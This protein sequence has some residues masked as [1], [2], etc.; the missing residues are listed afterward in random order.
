MAKRR[1]KKKNANL[2][3]A[4]VAIAFAALAVCTL[5]MPVFTTK[6]TIVKNTTTSSVAGKDLLVALFNGEISSD[7]TE[8]ANRMILL[9]NSDDNGTLTTIFL[10]A[11][12]A[13][14]CLSGLTAVIA[15]LS[16]LNIKLKMVAMLVGVILIIGAIVTLILAFIVNGKFT[17][18]D[19]GAFATVKNAVAIG[20]YLTLGGVLAGGALAYGNAK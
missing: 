7:Y 19:W 15:L 8:G 12:F 9:K 14:I 20:G 17:T 5:F 11:Y 10:I 3:I 2:L 1:T 13:T 6:V 18:L 16:V 4:I